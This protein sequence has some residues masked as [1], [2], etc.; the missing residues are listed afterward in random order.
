MSSHLSHGLKMAA[1]LP[2][3]IFSEIVSKIEK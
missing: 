2:G 3:I 1:S